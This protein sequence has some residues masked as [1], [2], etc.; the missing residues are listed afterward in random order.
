[1]FAY[2][3]GFTD[4]CQSGNIVGDVQSSRI[5][6]YPLG[7][8]LLAINEFINGA[9]GPS[10]RTFQIIDRALS[11]A[12][13]HR[14]YIAEAAG[15]NPAAPTRFL[16]GIMLNFSQLTTLSYWL[17]MRP[18]YASILFWPFIVFFGL[19]F[20]AALILTLYPW[21][22]WQASLKRRLVTPIWIFA[23]GGFVLVFFRYQAIPYLS[24]RIVLALFILASFGWIGYSLTV[25]R[26]EIQA[27]KLI[28]DRAVR[29]KKY[30]PK[31]RQRH[32]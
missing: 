6:D 22:I 4:K 7:P 12:V 26:K 5:F 24:L 3:T 2:P 17:E 30:L 18:P 11:S 23:L 21:Q 14:V 20:G 1:M 8:F 19:V 10:P 25:A 32:I 9:G 16:F 28:H 27:D 31:V 29:M 13:E 15:S